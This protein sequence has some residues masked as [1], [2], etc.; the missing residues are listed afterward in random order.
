M[1]INPTSTLLQPY[2]GDIRHINDHPPTLHKINRDS[3][4]T[5]LRCVFSIDI[6][7]DYLTV[8]QPRLNH[9]SNIVKPYGR[10]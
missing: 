6:I 2:F 5:Q 9:D 1:L 3:T 4:A 10:Q 8:I 7:L